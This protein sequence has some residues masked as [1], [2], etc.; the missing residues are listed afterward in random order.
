MKKLEKL[1]YQTR[2]KRYTMKEKIK[3][4]LWIV[5]HPFLTVRFAHYAMKVLAAYGVDIED[6]TKRN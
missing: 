5:R 2:D 6:I 1:W 3:N 4:F